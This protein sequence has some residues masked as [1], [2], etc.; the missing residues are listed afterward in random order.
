[1]SNYE[2]EEVEL[3]Y[4]QIL[5]TFGLI[6]SL[7]ISATLSY[8]EILKIENKKPLYSKKEEKN[9]LIFNRCFSSLIALGF[10]YINIYEKKTSKQN[11]SNLQ[12]SASTLTLIASLLVLYTAFN[13]NNSVQNIDNPE[14]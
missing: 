5:L 7:L 13:D 1:M 11:S 9:I 14:L 6:I 10:L 12:I 2:L 4:L 3:F 8:N